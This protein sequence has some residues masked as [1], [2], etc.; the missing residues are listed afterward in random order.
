MLTKKDIQ[1]FKTEV[2]RELTG[3]IL[4]FWCE[5]TIDMENGGFYGR[6]SN[7]LIIN[8]EA[9]KSC[10]LNS[11][12]LWTFAAA[13]RIFKDA[14]YRHV[15]DRAYD[16]LVNYFW[17]DQY[18]GL[19]FTL[20]YHGKVIDPRKQLYNLAF[21]IYGLSE[22]YR[23]TGIGESLKLAIQ[24]YG[25]IEEQFY[26]AQNKGYYEACSR[27]WR[28]IDDMRLSSRDLNAKKTMNSHLHLM[29]AYTNLLRIWEDG[30]LRRSLDELILTIVERIIDPETFHFNLFFD[31]NWNS[32]TKIISLGHDIE[33]S[34]LLAEA[35]SLMGEEKTL[36]DLTN[37]SVK[38]ARKV[39]EA[40]C[41]R[42]NGGLYNELINGVS[43]ETVKIW[44]P[45]CEAMVGF[46]NAFELTGEEHF[47]QAAYQIWRFI[48]RFMIDRK[49]GEWFGE[50]FE[51]GLPNPNYDKV[52]P[53]KCPYH[54]GR[55][56]ME[57]IARLEKSVSKRRDIDER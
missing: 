6:V 33:G 47:L 35:A 30:R 32:K 31:E 3:G 7:D 21:G 56:C 12:I 20:D 43:Q 49:N 2:K 26:D 53:W 46:I 13:Y 14:A 41:D 50:V 54:N 55:A 18:Y 24:L 44:W 36:N 1:Q 45:Q 15:A 22:Y 48:D 40:G 39:Y 10:I 23:A 19:F 11:R 51:D 52:G 34:W 9:N 57:V 17:D 29:E 8:R 42:E 16:Y 37:L 38:M 28:L 25:L 27:D 4:P 5:K